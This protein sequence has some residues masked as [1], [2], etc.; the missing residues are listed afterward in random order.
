MRKL[1]V[2]YG[3]VEIEK[4]RVSYAYFYFYFIQIIKELT[5]TSSR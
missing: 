1:R 2:N 3:N 5:Y 4:I